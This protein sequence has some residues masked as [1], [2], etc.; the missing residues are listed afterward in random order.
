VDRGGDI[1]TN[2]MLST[3]AILQNPPATGWKTCGRALAV[4][5]NVIIDVNTCSVDPKNSAVDIANQIAAKA[6]A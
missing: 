2:G 6:P 5:N 4:R 1:N 3:I